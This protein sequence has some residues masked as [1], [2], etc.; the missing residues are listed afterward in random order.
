[1]SIC[2]FSI[3][4]LSHGISPKNVKFL[5]HS[6][7]P[8]QAASM[9]LGLLLPYSLSDILGSFWNSFRIG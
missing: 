9:A 6:M 8:F 2:K 4:V 1:L 3:S 7:E 5:F